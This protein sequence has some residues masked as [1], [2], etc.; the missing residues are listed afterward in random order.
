MA[1]IFPLP[2][3]I[4]PGFVQPKL[5]PSAKSLPPREAIPNG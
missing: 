5:P 1:V 2:D 4:R 3:D